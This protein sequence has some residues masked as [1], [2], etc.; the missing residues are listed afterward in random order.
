MRG[1][2]PYGRTTRFRCRWMILVGLACGLVFGIWLGFGLK[3]RMVS[4]VMR[5]GMEV[6]VAEDAM[7]FAERFT[8]ETSK[9]EWDGVAVAMVVLDDAGDVWFASPLAHTVMCPASALKVLTTGAALGVMGPDFRF[10]TKLASVVPVGDVL[11]EDLVIVGG[12]DPTLSKDQLVGMVRDLAALGVRRIDGRV[13]VDVS[14][15]PEHPMSEHWNWGDIGNAYGAG[16]YGL[17]VDHNR[18]VL[19]IRPAERAGEAAKFLGANA[20]LPEVAWHEQVRTGVEGSGEAVTVYSEPYGKRVTLRGQ[21]P[22][23]EGEV[24][25]KAAIPDPPALAVEVVQAALREQGIEVTGRLRPLVEAPHV[26]ANTHSARL[27][28]IIRHIHEVSDNLESQCLFLTLGRNGH[29]AAVVR[30]YWEARGVAFAALRMID[31]S[32]LARANMIRAVDLARVMHVALRE[33]SGNAFLESLPVYHG[34][35]VRSKLGWM[36]GVTTSVGVITTRSGRRM[37][38]AFMANGVSD[39]QAVRQLRERLRESVAE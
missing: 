8:E 1:M 20:R 39:S 22:A 19:R 18:M 30:E 27:M 10:E 7:V 34:G 29:A 11:E 15:F 33:P 35:K 16:A 21:V 32:G 36:S 9:P 25:V 4:V 23:G 13:R 3:Q 14:V 28:E 2:N 12:G 31:G 26:L 38:Y 37:T 17:N 24:M 6:P 5:S